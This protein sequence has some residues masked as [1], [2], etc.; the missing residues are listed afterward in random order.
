MWGACAFERELMGGV[1]GFALWR[2]SEE[3]SASKL[4]S[5]PLS[6]F[7]SMW[8]C[9]L[10]TVGFA[11]CLVFRGGVFGGCRSVIF[12]TCMQ[13]FSAVACGSSGRILVALS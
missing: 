8:N 10:L 5:M 4:Q 3:P 6:R 2:P 7:G 13:G 12:F 9:C 11:S 1:D